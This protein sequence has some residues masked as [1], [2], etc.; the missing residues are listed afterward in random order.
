MV[1]PPR[2]YVFLSLNA[3]RALSILAL[4][5]VFSS[6]ILIMVED[7]KAVRAGSTS[8]TTTDATGQTETYECDYYDNST[9]P[10]QPAGAFWA[11][12]NR[13]FIIA[14]TILMILS[15]IGWPDKFF[16]LYLPVLGHDFGVGILGGIQW[17]TAASILSHHVDAFPL[18]AGFFLFVAGCFNILLGLIFRSTAKDRR[19]ITTFRQTKASELLPGPV[20]SVGGKAVRVL[21]MANGSIFNE[22]TTFLSRSDS[23]GTFHS[24]DAG[25]GG[26][27]RGHGF[28]RQGENK[29]AMEGFFVKRP[30]D[31]LGRYHPE[32]PQYQSPPSRVRVEDEDEEEHTNEGSGRL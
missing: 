11:V 32:P 30:V 28:A 14:T 22:K 23:G 10:N 5:L 12:V 24:G 9:V 7:I 17:I 8:L 27:T 18:V 6:N 20:H 25:H 15:E 21:H 3:V 19:S 16:R 26:A 29:A 1:L 2:A 31:S 13:L 4:L